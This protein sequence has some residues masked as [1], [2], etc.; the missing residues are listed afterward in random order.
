MSEL[1]LY[2]YNASLTKKLIVVASSYEEAYKLFSKKLGIRFIPS[3]VAKYAPDNVVVFENGLDTCSTCEN[4]MSG[5]C[6]CSQYMTIY[7]AQ[8]LGVNG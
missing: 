7:K 3:N 6:S 2:V 8:D 5:H 1:S 4:G